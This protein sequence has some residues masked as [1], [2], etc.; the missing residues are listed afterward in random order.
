MESI[1]L[2]T[3]VITGPPVT[4]PVLDRNTG[5]MTDPPRVEVY[6]G[7]CRLQVKADINSNVVETTAGDREWTYLTASLQVPICGTDAIR[8]D[9]VAEMLTVAHDSTLVG[10]L[11][12]IQGLGQHKS[13]ATHRRFRVRELIA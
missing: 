8:Q 2:D 6:R 5:Q 7:P 1:F 11:F 13:D 4:K 12:N 9:H 10:R 3:C